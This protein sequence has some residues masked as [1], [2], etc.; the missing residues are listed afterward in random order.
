MSTYRT[1]LDG[2][3][4]AALARHF[5][6]ATVLDPAVMFGS[7]EDWLAEWPGILA[8]LDLLAVWAD[9]EGMVGAGCIRELADAIGARLPVVAIDRRGL[10]RSFGGVWANEQLVVDRGRVGRLVHGAPLFASEV[11]AAGRARRQAKAG[12]RPCR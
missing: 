4:L 10:L 7:N 2:R 9:E 11:L 3:Q 6:E 1:P 5:P 8:R 12:E